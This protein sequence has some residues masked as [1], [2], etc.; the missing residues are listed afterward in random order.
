MTLF[1]A[2]ALLATL[3]AAAVGSAES[4]PEDTGEGP[5][6]VHGRR[7]FVFAHACTVHVRKTAEAEWEEVGAVGPGGGA[8]PIPRCYAWR[9]SIRPLAPS[10]TW[11]RLARELRRAQVPGLRLG[12]LQITDPVLAHLKDLGQLQELHLSG[13]KNITDA[14]LVHLKGLGQLRALDLGYCGNITDAGLAHLEGLGQLRELHLRSCENITDAG[15]VH[16][17]ALRQL[18]VLNLSYC[19]NI[20]DAGL[21]HLEGLGQLRVLWLVGCENIT[22]AG[23]QRIRKALPQCDV[24]GRAIRL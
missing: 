4:A 11:G 5:S 3:L 23:V 1:A 7:E 20:T 9:V 13:C 8:V 14:G 15:L 16:L 6:P 19:E 18:R 21:A 12:G 22:D 2:A 17:K 10:W 24:N